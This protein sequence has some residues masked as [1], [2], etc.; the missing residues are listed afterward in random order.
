ML[1][2]PCEIIALTT[3]FAPYFSEPVWQQAQVLMIGAILAPGRRTVASALRVMGLGNA[4]HFQNYHRVLNRATWSSRKVAQALFVLLLC[5]FTSTPLTGPIVLGV[6]ETLERR[7]GAKIAAKG[8]YRDATRSSHSF[9]VKATGLRWVVVM[10][11]VPIPWAKRVWALPFFTVL[12]PSERYH[13]ERGL[14]HKKSHRLGAADDPSGAPLA[15]ATIVGRRSRRRLFRTALTLAMC[16]L[17]VASDLHYPSAVGCSAL[18]TG[19]RTQAESEGSATQKRQAPADSGATSQEQGD[20]MDASHLDRLLWRGSPDR[21]NRLRHGRLVSQWTA[22]R[23]PSVGID[24]RSTREVPTTGS[25]LHRPDGGP[26]SDCYL[27]YAPLAVGG[28]LPGSACPSGS[29]NPTAMER[30]R[31]PA[32]NASV[33]GFVFIGD[34]LCQRMEGAGLIAHSSNGL[35]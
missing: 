10:L 33:D 29:R 31:H 5:T 16:A 26:G 4:E 3:A 2:L 18:R 6:D 9:F 32:H 21:G 25:S 34:P 22:R 1:N 35:V 15:A 17:V 27:V 13:Q 11:L 20:P 14:R 7:R 28:N 24:T 30:P 12:A 19:S 23:P 8:V